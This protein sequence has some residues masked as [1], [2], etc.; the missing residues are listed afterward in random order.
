MRQKARQGRAESYEFVISSPP[1]A[2]GGYAM[3]SNAIHAVSASVRHN[4]S[5]APGTVAI[6]IAI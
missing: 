1:K 2:C 3:R 4:L 6:A 5:P